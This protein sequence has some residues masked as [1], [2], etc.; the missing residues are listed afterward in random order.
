MEVNPA[1][2]PVWAVGSLTVSTGG[3]VMRVT[4]I[5][6]I[7]ADTATMVPA[8]DPSGDPEYVVTVA[9]KPM[10]ADAET[11]TCLGCLRKTHLWIDATHTIRAS[12]RRVRLI[13]C[14]RCFLDALDFCDCEIHTTSTTVRSHHLEPRRHW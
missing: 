9:L 7:R 5:G 13:R 8:A 14:S 3:R 11:I 4:A 12:G 2:H 1:A 6:D 10:P